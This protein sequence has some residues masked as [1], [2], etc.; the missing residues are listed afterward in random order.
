[1]VC[2]LSDENTQATNRALNVPEH[3][4]DYVRVTLDSF[5]LS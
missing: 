3:E 1:M 2:V 5:S 4:G